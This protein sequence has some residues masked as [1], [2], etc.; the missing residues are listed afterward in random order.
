MYLGTG[1]HVCVM[2]V[3]LHVQTSMWTYENVWAPLDLD[4]YG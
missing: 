2:H 4:M 3:F 1:V